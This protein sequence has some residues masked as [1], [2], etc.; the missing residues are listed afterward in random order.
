MN[1]EICNNKLEWCYMM[2]GCYYCRQSMRPFNGSCKGS[3]ECVETTEVRYMNCK[4]CEKLKQEKEKKE[5]ELL[6]K[7][8]WN[9]GTLK[10]KLNCY[11]VIKLKLLA[12]QKK[13]K[14]Y[15]TMSKC[16]LIANLISVCVD[17]DL[18]IK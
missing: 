15:S 6:F 12:K 1:C 17:N 3:C 9:T 4:N 11:G 16:V 14:K 5:K 13:I 10:E 7:N 18:P 8:K 2:S